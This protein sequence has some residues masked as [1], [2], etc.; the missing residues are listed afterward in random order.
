MDCIHSPLTEKLLNS[1]SKNWLSACQDLEQVGEAYC[2]ATVIADAGS[3]PRARGSKMVISAH[4]QFDT[5]GGGKLEF[6]VIQKAREGLS[7]HTTQPSIERFSLAADLGQ[8]CGGA[9]QILFEFMHTQQPKVVVFGAGHVCQ[10]LATILNS[11]PCHLTVVDNRPEWLSEL[12]ECGVTTRLEEDP[13]TVI[14]DLPADAHL[15]VMTQDHSLDFEITRKALE[16]EVFPF[17]GL[18]GSEAKKQRFSFRLAEQLSDADKLAALTCP[19][20][21]PDVR[22]KLP[23]QVAVSISSQLIGLFEQ[24]Q[25]PVN[26]AK[27]QQHS[28][29]DAN[30]LRKTLTEA[31]Q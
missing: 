5:L 8:C 22:G 18:I 27:S 25:K 9:V 7:Q 26:S 12:S 28:W 20:G 15:V 10:S 30:N 23:M 2:I 4:H 14:D 16:R 13:S 31:C 17:V 24:T 1:P 21:H 29:Q 19:I 11:L 3:V 6:Q